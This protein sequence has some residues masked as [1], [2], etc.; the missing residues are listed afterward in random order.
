MVRFSGTIQAGCFH[1]VSSIAAAGLYKGV[2]REDMFEEAE[3]LQ[4]AYFA[5]KHKS[6]QLV[7][8][9]C[10][11]PW[12]IYRP[13][14]VGG[15]QPHRLKWKRSTDRII[16]SN[17]FNNCAGIL[18]AWVPAIGLEGGR[19]NLVPV[20]FVAAALD[21]L[22]HVPG[23]DGRCFHLTDPAPRRVGDVL[24]IFA[25]A[26]HAPQMALRVNAGL[27]NMIPHGLVRSLMVLTPVKRIRDLAM[28]E[29]GLPP[30][31]LQFVNYPTRFDCREAQKL[32][33]P[34]GITVPPL[35]DYAWRLWDYWERELD[36]DLFVDRSLRGR[37]AGQ[38]VLVTGG[39]AGIGHA[40]ALK[41]ARAGATTLIVGARCRKAE[42][43]AG[44]GCRRWIAAGSL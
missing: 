19:I 22:A 38:V 16:S 24:N 18:P 44:G 11:I 40:A 6:E 21:H 34:A 28:Q 32:L 35:E 23:Q 39:S 31:M 9:S 12:R 13:G 29:F 30:D 41:I 3:G 10:P 20:D 1:H 7:R 5:S 15:R 26:G 8:Q 27:L 42:A 2:F 25:R 43:G 14:I 33:A 4:H 17:R 37:V 36:P